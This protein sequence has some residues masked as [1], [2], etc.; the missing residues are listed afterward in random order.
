[1]QNNAAPSNFYKYFIRNGLI[2]SSF[3]FLLHL[4][5]K[6]DPENRIFGNYSVILVILIILFGIFLTFFVI[7]YTQLQNNNLLTSKIHTIFDH[8]LTKLIVSLITIGSFFFLIISF[9]LIKFF[10]FSYLKAILNR[11]F[12]LILYFCLLSFLFI[13]LEKKFLK[14]NTIKSGYQFSLKFIN[15]SMKWVVNLS[16]RAIPNQVYFVILFIATS[17]FYL[18]Y[19]GTINAPIGIAGLYT[20]M[21]KLIQ[22]NH[23]IIPQTVPYY[24]P[25]GIPF[26]YPPLGFYLMAFLTGP[27]GISEMEY[28]RWAPALFSI[29]AMLAVFLLVK[30]SIDIKTALLSI[31]LLF[32]SP[33]LFL[34]HGEA[35]GIIRGLAFVFLLFGLYFLSKHIKEQKFSYLFLGSLFFTLVTLTHLSYSVFFAISTL[36]IFMFSNL[37]WRNKF[38]GITFVAVVGITFSAPWW[39]TIIN[40]YGYE[41]FLN[42]L[43]SHNNISFLST[44]SHPLKFINDSWI[45]YNRYLSTTPIIIGLSIVGFFI[46]L[47]KKYLLF[48]FLFLASFFISE[49]DRYQ[50]TIASILAA[51]TV[52][53]IINHSKT[54]GV[55]WKRFSLT[56]FVMVLLFINSMP[57][58]N[59]INQ[60]NTI[61]VNQNFLQLT[62]WLKSNA[63]INENYLFLSPNAQTAEWLPYLSECT[64]VVGTW[65]GEWIG[66]Y[67]IQFT[68]LMEIIG[69]GSNLTLNC[70]KEID[71]KYPSDFLIIEINDPDQTFDLTY[72]N[73]I[74]ESYPFLIYK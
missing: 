41:V 9:S 49:G 26:A 4:F 6:S 61:A 53:S 16:N 38:F 72:R 63:E 62:T 11:F 28:L 64:P 33:R 29:F 54:D 15:K 59:K 65:G 13:Y 27:I 40:R 36:L 42:A 7:F 35:A 19:P 14:S 70:V 52:F 20:L 10:G 71:S 2:L 43:Q 50:V 45:E 57:S 55:I 39:I 60:T 73:L 34:F 47:N 12:L 48:P 8:D 3:F 23:F 44:I 30:E 37:H 67:T 66:T 69:C 32:T 21:A 24:G 68:Q 46:L 31:L 1:M 51:T 56:V 18:Y 58:I 25:G 5:Q 17:C 22:Q 74:F